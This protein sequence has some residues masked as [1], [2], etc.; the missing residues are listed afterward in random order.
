M[1]S[2]II[3]IA[4]FLILCFVLLLGSKALSRGIEAKNLNKTIKR[5]TVLNNTNK[6]LSKSLTKEIIKLKKLH[7]KG[8]LTNKEFEDAKKKILG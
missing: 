3:Y 8:I 4:V 5:D 7:E 6:K 2:W 1:I